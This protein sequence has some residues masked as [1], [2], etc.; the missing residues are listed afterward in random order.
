MFERFSRGWS[1]AKASFAVLRRYPKLMILPALSGTAFLILA[2]LVLLTLLPQL[3]GMNGA[4]RPFWAW[5]DHPDV[6]NLWFYAGLFAVVF[7]LTTISVFFNVA[8]IHCALR[9]HAGERPSIRDGLAAAGRL[10]P[11]ILGWALIATTVGLVLNMLQDAL[12]NYLGFLGSLF[13][14]LLELSWAVITWFVVPVLVTEKVGPVT[15]ARRS[16]AIIRAKWGESLTGNAGINLIGGLVFL[17][18]AL[19]FAGGAAIALSFGL[20]GKLG[21]GLVLMLVGAAL[22][23]VSMVAAQA[24]TA[25]FQSGVY[26]YATTGQV[27]ASLD[28]AL[29]ETAFEPKKA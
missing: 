6:T 19:I 22:A 1:M 24:L 5:L 23:L 3:G 12:K 18:A 21:L 29:V 20:T 9:A 11:Q 4:T 15:A 8:M 7:V 10:S 13:G 27:P 16:A 17:V 2:G 26:L 25:I 28:R 14:G